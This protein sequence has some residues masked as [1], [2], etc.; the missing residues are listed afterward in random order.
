MKTLKKKKEE[1]EEGDLGAFCD[2]V[3]SRRRGSGCKAI[4][5]SGFNVSSQTLVAARTLRCCTTGGFHLLPRAA[6]FS[7]FPPLP[8]LFFPFFSYLIFILPYFSI[9]FKIFLF[10]Y[11][12]F[13]FPF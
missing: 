7:S 6:C 8:F 9:Y 11:F 12:P 2:F 10:L 3:F 5:V 4:P 1:E 13:Y